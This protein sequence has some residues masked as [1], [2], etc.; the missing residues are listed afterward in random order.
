MYVIKHKQNILF[1][2]ILFHKTYITNCGSHLAFSFA[3]KIAGNLALFI[4]K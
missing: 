4:A 2:N 1:F 3:K